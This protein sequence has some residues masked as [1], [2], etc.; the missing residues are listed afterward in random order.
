MDDN[1]EVEEAGKE[2]Q[3]RI[4]FGVAVALFIAATMLIF[5]WNDSF[6]SDFEFY[7][8][9]IEDNKVSSK[10]MPPVGLLGIDFGNGQRRAFE[11][12][13]EN[14]M[15]AVAALRAATRVGKLEV[16]T[17]ERGRV[18]NIAGVKN[19]GEKRWRVYLNGAT[20]A[21]LPGNI[22]VKGGDRV[23]FRYE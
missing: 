4:Y 20:I 17:D 18:T 19:N 22:L 11:G 1:K 21:D 8:T 13:V 3:S 5:A 9:G 23:M 14:G 2:T 6:Y 16:A 7:F 12:P 15:T 10:R